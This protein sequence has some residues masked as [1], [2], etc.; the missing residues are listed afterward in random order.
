MLRRT[1]YHNAKRAFANGKPVTLMNIGVTI[2]LNNHK[3][4]RKSARYALF[5]EVL[6]GETLNKK[7][8]FMVKEK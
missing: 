1:T 4:L 8:E 3:N 7:A 5:K 2:Q 6:Y